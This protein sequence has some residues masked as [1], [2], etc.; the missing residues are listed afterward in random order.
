MAQGPATSSTRGASGPNIPGA[1]QCL[2]LGCRGSWL[3]S[4]E[5]RRTEAGRVWLWAAICEG[6]A[7]EGG[8]AGRVCGCCAWADRARAVVAAGACLHQVNCSG[9]RCALGRGRGPGSLARCCRRCWGALCL[10]PCCLEGAR[11]WVRLAAGW[12]GMPRGKNT[13]RGG[14]AADPCARGGELALAGLC[15]ERL[16]RS[17]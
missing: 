10:L 13:Y 16:G 11:F 3:R 5:P 17:A 7:R 9:A 15:G 2:A 8:F 1:P 4:P 12:S 6:E 14:L